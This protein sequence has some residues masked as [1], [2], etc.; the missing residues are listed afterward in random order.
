VVD[1]RK[2]KSLLRVLRDAGVTSYTSGDLS[3]TFGDRNAQI[4]PE[5]V[6]AAD[7]ET[8]APLD[9]PEGVWD[10]RHRVAEINRKHSG[11]RTS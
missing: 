6:A 5:P 9:L 3:V 4:A 1:S 8:G 7:G 2:L 11:G 10:P